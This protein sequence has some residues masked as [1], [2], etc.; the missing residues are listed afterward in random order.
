MRPG[1]NVTILTAPPDNTFPTDTGTWFAAGVASQGPTGAQLVTSFQQFQSVY[2]NRGTNPTL[3]DSMETF[4]KEGGARAYVARVVGPAA[5][6]ALVVLNDSVPAPSLLVTAIGPGPYA[7]GYKVV[8]VGT[9]TNYTIQ[10]QDSASNVLETSNTLTSNADAVGY[11]QTSSYVVIKS[12][13][14]NSPAAGTFTLAGGVDDT[15]NIT[16]TQ[17]TNALNTFA[18]TL[19]PGQVSIPGA[20]ATADITAIFQH[21]QNNN[22]IALCDLADTS[23]VA[24]LTSAAASVT[25]LGPAARSGSLWAP[26]VD[27]QP[28]SG[29]TGLRSVP[30]CA[31][32]AAKCAQ[33]DALGNPN[34]P[35]AG[36]NG[37][38]NTPADLHALGATGTPS[39]TERSTLNL[40]GVNVI[41]SVGSSFRIYGF[42]T[43]VNWLTDPNYW[44]LNNARLDMAIVAKSQAIEENYVFT[45]IDGQGLDAA[46]YGNDLKS[47]L[48]TYYR[49]GA[50]YGATA[51]DAFVVDTGPDVN[52]PALNATG[53][54]AATIACRRSPEAEQ[55][56]LNIV[57]V[58]ITQAV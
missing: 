1:T 53:T 57:R 44:Q 56:N 50:L 26:W 11:G 22:R 36:Q 3:S 35:A 42:R 18:P 10:I 39:D 20:T 6:G 4:F 2:G 15:T 16:T 27:I 5:T 14:A 40:A 19:G 7:N 28:L 37:I 48:L 25:A 45:Q 30:P 8:I 13:G 23:T 55:V 52:T 47:M 9:P 58:P 46:A 29:S 33:V 51:A 49:M 31:F 17:R 21:A 24:T 54:L 41:K 38:L 12:L 32:V 43:A 34:V